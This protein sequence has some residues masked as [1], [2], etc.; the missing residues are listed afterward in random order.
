MRRVVDAIAAGIL[1][2]IGG[3]VFLACAGDGMKWLGAILFAVALLCICFKGYSLFTGKVGYLVNDH[4][5]D[6]WHVVGT[7]LLGNAIACCGV[8][9]I[10]AYAMPHL[11]ATAATICAAKLEQALFSTI[12]RAILC[13][14]LMYM[15]VSIYRE[16]GSIAGIFFC[17][18]VFI[19]AGF[20][21]SIANM[22]YFGAANMLN[23]DSILYL[24]V[25]ILG[26]AV[27]GMLFPFLDRFG[28]KK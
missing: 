13:G 12:V 15:A 27:G 19:L 11:G 14:V 3:C 22:C 24:C 18:P 26:N 28:S 20:E 6:Y 5:K 1:I 7:S 16:K 4:S 10:I 17:V 2:S 9:L 8:G 23:V 21:H 25:V